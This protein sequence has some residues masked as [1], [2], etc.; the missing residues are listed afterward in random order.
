[1]RAYGFPQTCP[2]IL[3]A[4]FYLD[5]VAFFNGSHGFLAVQVPTIDLHGY[6][7]EFE[8]QCVLRAQR[9]SHPSD[10][11][12]RLDRNGHIARLDH[13]LVSCVMPQYVSPQRSDSETVQS[14]VTAQKTQF[15]GT[16]Q[17]PKVIMPLG[18][19]KVGHIDDAE[20][21]RIFKQGGGSLGSS[22]MASAF[23]K[24]KR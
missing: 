13:R 15:F 12:A 10:L 17:T 7:P 9:S 4:R 8:Q 21:G 1:M 22:A 6:C 16:P 20:R 5:V 18:G 24:L 11:Q 23:A 2:S 3:N 14:V 19:V